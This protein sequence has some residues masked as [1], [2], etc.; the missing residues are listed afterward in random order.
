MFTG[1]KYVVQNIRDYKKVVPHESSPEPEF[2]QV[3]S[4]PTDVWD[5]DQLDVTVSDDE[6]L[7]LE[8]NQTTGSGRYIAVDEA[9][10]QELV[11]D[12]VL[13]PTT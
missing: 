13:T 8:Q 6:V 7:L 5:Y 11:K 9:Q 3:W 2:V 1:T 10:M 12:K 4:D